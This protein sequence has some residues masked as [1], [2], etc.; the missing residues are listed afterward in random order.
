MLLDIIL[1]PFVVKTKSY[2][3]DMGDFLSKVQG[4]ELN[5]NDWMFSMDVTSLYINLPHYDGIE[6]FKKVLTEHV[7]STP[8][9]SSLIKL[10]EFV[11]KS[12]NFVFNWDNYLQINGTAMGTRVSPTYANLFMNSLEQ[13][14]IYPHAKCPRI[15]FRFIDDIWGIFRGTEEELNSFVEY[16]NSFHETIK[17]MVEH[18]K[19]SIRRKKSRQ[20][21]LSNP[22]I[23]IVI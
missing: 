19:K 23:V 20:H 13:T 16:C 8:K 10:L 15:W 22:L 11:L 9:N 2:I 3:R 6:C 21:C 1:Q 18:S 14:Y 4:V 17:F 7:N 5:S 12:N